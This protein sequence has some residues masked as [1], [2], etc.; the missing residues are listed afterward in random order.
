MYKDIFNYEF[1]LDYHVPK[2]DMCDLCERFRMA[3]NTEKAAMQATYNLH[4]HNKNLSRKN[5]E[6]DDKEREKTNS[7]LVTCFDLQQVL[8]CPKG[9]ASN[10]YYRRELIAYNL[11]IYILN[12][13]DASCFM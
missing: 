4:Q 9:E 3:S 1:N 8:N 2:K 5:K 12:T 13:K 6:E 7:E 11:S 10:F